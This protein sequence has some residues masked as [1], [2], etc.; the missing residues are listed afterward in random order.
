MHC[1]YL[2]LTVY[3][4]LWRRNTSRYTCL[5]I[6]VYTLQAS[7][8]EALKVINEACETFHIFL[9]VKDL[10]SMDWRS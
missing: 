2:L 5:T 10:E 4:L 8:F 1:N 9:Q 3:K 6:S 7:K